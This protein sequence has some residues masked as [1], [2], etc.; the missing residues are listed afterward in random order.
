MIRKI[1]FA[2]ATL[3]AIGCSTQVEENDDTTSAAADAEDVGSV[4]QGL[5]TSTSQTVTAGSCATT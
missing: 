4:E 1:L 2:A 5:T 3:A